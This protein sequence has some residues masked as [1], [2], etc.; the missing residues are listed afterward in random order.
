MQEKDPGMT[1]DQAKRVPK[2]VEDMVEAKVEMLENEV[3]KE[4]GRQKEDG[5]EEKPV[6]EEDKVEEERKEEEKVEQ[7]V[8]AKPEGMVER[9]NLYATHVVERAIRP[10]YA[11][12]KA[13]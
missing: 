7:K 6:S 9:E 2:E 1:E 13:G 11:H 4:E 8:M 12:Q 3:G 10:G 5:M